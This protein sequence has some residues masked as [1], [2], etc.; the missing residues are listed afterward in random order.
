REDLYYSV[1][2][3][4]QRGRKIEDVLPTRW[5]WADLDEVHPSSATAL[6][7]MP[8][9]AIESS[10]GRFQALWRLSREVSVATLEKL[11]RGLTYAL[12]ADKGGWDLTQVLRIP[13]T[14]NFK[15]EGA[16]LV[17]LLWINEETYEPQGIWRVVR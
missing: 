6:G 13:G 3:F 2:Q 17:R 16:P 8:T 4:S 11:N 14:R 15:Y 10:P 5:L 7:L 9:V 1:A 12:D